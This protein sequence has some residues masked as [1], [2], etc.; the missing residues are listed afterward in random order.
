[1]YFCTIIYFLLFNFNN[2]EIKNNNPTNYKSD[3]YS[4]FSSIDTVK[5]NKQIS[6]ISASQ[7]AE[8]KAYIGALLMRKAGLVSAISNKLSL[9]LEGRKL[10]EAAISKEKQNAEYRFLRLAIQE[11]CPAILQYNSKI[12]EDVVII[13]QSY[14]NFTNEL[15]LAVTD[16]S[17]TSKALK[18]SDL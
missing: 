3:Y 18:V 11:N 16:Y 1:M 8:K 15:K 10:L 12:D 4:A 6:Q 9:F 14:S 2:Y 7:I 5:I 13:R 17:K